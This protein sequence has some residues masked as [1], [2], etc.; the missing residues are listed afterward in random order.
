MAELLTP[1]GYAGGKCG[2]RRMLSQ[3]E[4]E[5]WEKSLLTEKSLSVTLQHA[6]IVVFHI[7]EQQ[8]TCQDKKSWSAR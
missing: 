7:Q 4:I 1:G 8:S 2:H 3:E 5:E 6:N